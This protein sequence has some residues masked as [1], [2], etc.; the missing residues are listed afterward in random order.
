[1]KLV[2]RLALLAIVLL[3]WCAVARP[4]AGPAQVRLTPD[5]ALVVGLINSERKERNQEALLIDPVLVAVARR[6]SEDMARRQYFSHLAPPPEPRTPLD[7]YAAALGRPPKTVV[8]ENIA[9]AD[10]P[11]MGMIHNGMM[12]SPDHK[13]NILDAEYV[14]LGVGIYAMDDGRVWVTQMLRGELPKTR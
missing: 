6:H 2:T 1:M 7:R 8:G 12:A 13:A 11:V 10:E 9:R 14:S 3:A 4:A 5:E